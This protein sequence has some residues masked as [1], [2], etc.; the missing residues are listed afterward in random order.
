MSKFAGDGNRPPGAHG[1]G[2]GADVARHGDFPGHARVARRAE[3]LRRGAM[4]CRAKG[5]RAQEPHVNS[6]ANQDLPIRRRDGGWFAKDSPESTERPGPHGLVSGRCEMPL[7]GVEF[8]AQFRPRQGVFFQG[9]QRNF[10]RQFIGQRQRAIPVVGEPASPRRD[11][12]GLQ[13]RAGFPH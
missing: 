6:T 3:F 12:A 9:E 5:I 2:D 7:A 10:R 8:R 11:L 1:A 13:K 4:K